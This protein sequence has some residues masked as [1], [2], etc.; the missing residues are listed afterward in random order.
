MTN[1]AWHSVGLTDLVTPVTTTYRNDWQFSKDD[2]TTNSCCYLLGALHTK[3]NMSIAV[4]NGN[5]GLE[6]CALAC[7]GLFLHWHDFENFIFQGRPKEEVNDLMLLK[8]Q[9]RKKQVNESN[10]N[11]SITAITIY[12]KINLLLNMFLWTDACEYLDRKRKEVN[13][14]QS[15]DL[16]VLNQ[17]AKFS[18]RH[19]LKVKKQ[20]SHLR[21][22]DLTSSYI[23]CY[24]H[25]LILNKFITI[26]WNT[27][28]EHKNLIDS[29]NGFHSIPLRSSRENYQLCWQFLQHFPPYLYI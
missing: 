9:K 19:P 26:L 29:T 20:S 4:S 7:S 2:G 14:L 3:T 16:H 13:L 24:D 28:A 6:A 10:L 27:E 1:L 25:Y 11:P 23:S 12:N 22:E 15:F 17:A 8:T 21:V 5:K 18:Y